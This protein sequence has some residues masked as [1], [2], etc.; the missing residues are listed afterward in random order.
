MTEKK[1]NRSRKTKGESD[2]YKELDEQLSREYERVL[3]R[4]SDIARPEFKNK[5]AKEGADDRK[6]SDTM[7]ESREEETDTMSESHSTLSDTM[8]ESNATSENDSDILSDDTKTL[9]DMVS[10][11]KKRVSPLGSVS[12][13]T[14][15]DTETERKGVSDRKNENTKLLSSTILPL[16]SRASADAELLA[17]KIIECRER[18]LL[19]LSG[20]RLAL[21]VIACAGS[22]GS[23]RVE[24]PLFKLCEALGLSEKTGYRFARDAAKTS[25]FES[26]SGNCGQGTSFV[27][28]KDIWIENNRHEREKDKDKEFVSLFPGKRH[29]EDIYFMEYM[30][31]AHISGLEVYPGFSVRRRDFL[32]KF[33]DSAEREMFPGGIAPSSMRDS[34]YEEASTRIVA[35]WFQ[36]SRNTQ[37][38][39]SQPFAF[40][41][42]SWEKK[43]FPSEESYGI[44]ET[45]SGTDVLERMSKETEDE[46]K[47][48]VRTARLI[49][50]KQLDVPDLETLVSTA[51][52]FGIQRAASMARA[53]MV[54][55]ITQAATEKASGIADS[56]DYVSKISAATKRFGRNFGER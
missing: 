34:L 4:M 17:L 2:Y 47:H 20:E 12:K 15:P 42:A 54:E 29:I 32:G 11:T 52:L 49:L 5:K 55:A 6:L 50:R 41:M 35:A 48:L 13:K 40:L 14:L 26:V 19:S 53:E 23:R 36:V 31:S 1:Y 22:R 37:S 24:I 38:R 30:F 51:A 28:S 25:L 27:I 39:I 9:S 45:S 7:S 18:G 16:F 8:S 33:L 43:T 46:A 3:S 10:A 44:R 21:A 56:F